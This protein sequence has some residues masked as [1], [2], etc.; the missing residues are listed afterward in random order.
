MLASS[1]Q[2]RLVGDPSVRGAWQLASRVREASR[3]TCRALLDSKLGISRDS[4]LGSLARRE[5][6]KRSA[7]KYS[8]EE[9]L[10]RGHPRESSV[11]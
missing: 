8:F 1:M 10:L 11:A 6:I 7:S 2:T 4:F 3:R 5:P 9:T